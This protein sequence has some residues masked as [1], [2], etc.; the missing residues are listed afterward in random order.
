[1]IYE[2]TVWTNDMYWTRTTE[3]IA[4]S[5]DAAIEK[6]KQEHKELS[7]HLGAGMYISITGQREEDE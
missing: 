4:S 5:S 3:V 7:I 6:F 1:M 2:I